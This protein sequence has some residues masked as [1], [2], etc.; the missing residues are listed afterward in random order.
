MILAGIPSESD[1]YDD[2]D[3]LAEEDD[4]GEGFVWPVKLEVTYEFDAGFMQIF[5]KY[6]LPI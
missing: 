1:D 5:E 2:A 6:D 4:R 3:V